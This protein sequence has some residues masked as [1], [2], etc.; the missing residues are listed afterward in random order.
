MNLNRLWIFYN[1]AK[2]KGFSSAAESLFLTQP[3]VSTQIKLLEDSYNIKLFERYGKKIRLTTAGEVLLSYAERIFNLAKKADSVI[4][5][6]KKVNSGC[7]KISASLTMGTYYLPSILSVFKMKY[8]NIEI[9]M[10]V[11][12]S[13][14]VIE[15]IL[16]FNSD[17]GF[18][19]H[20]VP[21][22]KL[23]IAPFVEEE[24]VIIVPSSHEFANQKTIK[25]SR[26]NGQHFIMREKGSGTREDIENKFKKENISVRVIM[27]LGSNEAIKR[28]VEAGLGISIISVNIV[29]RE[30]D[31]G[32]IKAIRLGEGKIIRSFY[33]IYHKDKYLSSIIR[34]FLS[35]ASDL[36][37]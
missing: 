8:P 10:K 17:L 9:Q 31:A 4:E 26:L 18:I 5:D 14:E 34:T 30:V 7:L 1:V 35:M 2:L 32:L 6:V 20:I 13:E 3:A 33:T 15:N 23:I 36:S 11:G 12:N 16:S 25:L 28:A 19:G 21:I 24:L 37:I 29:K 27:E 22:E